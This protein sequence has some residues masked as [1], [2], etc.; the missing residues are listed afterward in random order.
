[1]EELQSA[2]AAALQRM[3]AEH[4]VL[5]ADLGKSSGVE[6]DG[7]RCLDKVI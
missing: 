3:Q 6:N 4:K 7:Q 2:H 1:M 5:K